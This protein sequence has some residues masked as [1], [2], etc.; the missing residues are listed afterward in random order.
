MDDNLLSRVICL[1]ARTSAEIKLTPTEIDELVTSALS[2]SQR[3]ARFMPSPVADAGI[4]GQ[5]A[6]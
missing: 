2:I 5:V 3:H 1:S 4:P 6:V